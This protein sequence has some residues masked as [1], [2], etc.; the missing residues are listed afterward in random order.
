MTLADD[1]CMFRM[2]DDMLDTSQRRSALQEADLH[3]CPESAMCRRLV[4]HVEL[5][6][7]APADLCS[8][9][10]IYKCCTHRGPDACCAGSAVRR[11]HVVVVCCLPPGGRR[12]EDGVR[13][14]VAHQLP[15][16]DQ[17]V[18]PTLQRPGQSPVN[19]V[20]GAD[21]MQQ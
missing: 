8:V 21:M 16:P 12:H 11:F 7:R 19:L 15:H 9:H 1:I 10:E 4:M 17:L 6:S 20:T 18:P 3:T 5:H 13:L 14:G 2:K